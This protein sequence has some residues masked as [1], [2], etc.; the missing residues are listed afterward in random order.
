MLCCLRKRVPNIWLNVK[1]QARIEASQL[2]RSE[3]SSLC[4]EAM[5]YGSAA[6]LLCLALTRETSC[7]CDKHSD[8]AALAQA[9]LLGA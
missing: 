4:C 2:G 1:F 9:S 3:T 8:R 7:V 5:D 6:E